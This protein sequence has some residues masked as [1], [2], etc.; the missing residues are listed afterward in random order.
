M[1]DLERATVDEVTAAIAR[2]QCGGIRRRRR[3]GSGA[4]RKLTMDRD[5]AI[6]LLE[7]AVAA[8][9]ARYVIVSSVG[10]ED[11]PDDDDVFSVY[12]RA[13]AAADAAVRQ[14]SRLDDRQAGGLDRRSRHRACPDRLEPV[15]R[16]RRA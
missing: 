10:A 13:K 2:R 12:L 7:A 1:C 15:S 11:P 9:V 4:D 3:A 16:S 8:G 5:G 14:R 6:K